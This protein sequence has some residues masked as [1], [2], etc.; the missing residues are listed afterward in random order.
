M[1][2]KSALALWTDEAFFL[3]QL[4]DKACQHIQADT[5]IVTAFQLETKRL[6]L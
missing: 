6:N 5:A 4:Q 1:N 2:H 3:G